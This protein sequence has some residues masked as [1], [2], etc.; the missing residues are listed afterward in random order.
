MHIRIR[1]GQSLME[2]LV[3]LAL[4]ALF[5]IG[6]A[7]IVVPSLQT[8]KQ[9]ANIQVQAQLA[10]GLLNNVVAW[11]TENWNNILS[12]ATGTANTYYLNTSSSP[13]TVVASGTN[14]SWNGYTY[15]SAIT[16]TSSTSIA[17]GTNANFPML[18][19]S[20]LTSWEPTSTG[21]DIQNLVI[22][23]NGGQEPADL[24]FTSDS[25][26]TTPLDFETESYSSLTGA[27]LDWVNV[28]SLS[29]GSVIYAC[30]GNAAITT[31]QSHP[32]S[33]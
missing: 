20:A 2:L 29:A 5:I 14:P 28:P 12:L 18:I 17:S 6:S 19:S 32:S 9:V 1:S 8:N 21:G 13:F 4:G 23:P 22:A 33:T 25:G 27:I 30:Y 11:G 16:V 24:I 31:N 10:S 15:R 7:V 3:G 26:C